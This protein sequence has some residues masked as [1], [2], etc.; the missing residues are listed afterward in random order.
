MEKAIEVL[1]NEVVKCN[2]MNKFFETELLKYAHI[3]ADQSELSRLKRDQV[4]LEKIKESCLDA[5][6]YLKTIN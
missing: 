5:I 2:Y 1:K 3:T 6:K 4:E